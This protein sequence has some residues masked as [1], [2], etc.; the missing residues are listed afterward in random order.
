M[1]VTHRDAR[2]THYEACASRLKPA[3]LR[4]KRR[5]VTHVTHFWWFLDI[6]PMARNRNN[7]KISV[8][9]VTRATTAAQKW[10][11][12][13]QNA[14]TPSVTHPVTRCVTVRHVRHAWRF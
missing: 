13:R 2:V 4:E 10:P 6:E 14:V 8:T 7:C 11:V 9:C 1:S 12:C 5:G 3:W